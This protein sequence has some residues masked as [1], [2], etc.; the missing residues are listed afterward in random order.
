M[1]CDCV[2][3]NYIMEL[4][5]SRSFVLKTADGQISRPYCLRNGVTQES[6]FAP[7]LHNVYT[8]DIPKTNAN[9]YTYADDITLAALGSSF[10]RVENLL[11][12]YIETSRLKLSIGKTVRSAFHF[13]NRDAKCK[14]ARSAHGELIKFEASPTYLRV[15]L[16]RNFTFKLT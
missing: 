14:L 4:V 16:D 6:V 2:M 15:C 13:R 7:T 10:E 3:V 5:C 9:R 8:H 1:C 11:T 12:N